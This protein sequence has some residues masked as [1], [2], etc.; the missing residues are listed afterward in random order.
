[1]RSI[2]EKSTSK[3]KPGEKLKSE[4]TVDMHNHLLPALDDGSENMEI[5]ILLAKGLVERGYEKIFATPHIMNG[6][7]NND[8]EKILRKVSMLRQNLKE[9]N[10]DLLLDYAAEYY[11][12]DHFLA[13]LEKEIK[14]ITIGRNTN[15]V[16]IETSFV[17]NFNKLTNALESLINLGY[18]PVLAHPERYIYL[19]EANKR[20]DR[21]QNMGVLFQ[22]NI[23]SLGGYYSQQTKKKAEFLIEHDMVS[24]L[25]TN[26]HNDVQLQ[27]L[28]YAI[29][30]PYYQLAL[31]SS[32]LLNNAL[33]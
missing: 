12:D 30:N 24:F 17:E 26:C 23:N 1:M 7:Y 32:R 16:L 5:A 6:F 27:S 4:L 22:V 21:L 8:E 33:V 14:P 2:I 3:I 13:Q 19:E 31:S 9:E 25:G 29:T 20:Y 18:R 11:L 10:I 28:D 15:F